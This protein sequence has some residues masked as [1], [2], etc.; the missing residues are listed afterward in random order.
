M[1]EIYAEFIRAKQQCNEPVAGITQASL[2]ERLRGTVSKLRDS[3]QGKQIDFGVV[4]KDGRVVLK[5]VVKA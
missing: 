2:A 3:N 4:I 1:Q 5:P